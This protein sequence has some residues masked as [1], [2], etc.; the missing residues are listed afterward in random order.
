[1]SKLCKCGSGEEIK[2]GCETFV[3][4]YKDFNLTAVKIGLECKNCSFNKLKVIEAI[5][6]YG[7]RLI[8]KSLSGIEINWDFYCKFMEDN[9]EDKQSLNDILVALGRFSVDLEDCWVITDGSILLNPS[10]YASQL[11][12]RDRT[13]ALLYAKLKFSNFPHWKIAKISLVLKKSDIIK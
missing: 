3:F 2:A 6:E 10:W 8:K 11:Y 5:N 7:E 4:S 13:D 12:F 9:R 1:M